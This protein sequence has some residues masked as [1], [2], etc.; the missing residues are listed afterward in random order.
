M[1]WHFLMMWPFVVNGIVFVINLFVSGNWKE[2]FPDNKTFQKLIPF[3]LFDLHLNKKCPVF[4]GKYNPAQRVIYPAVIL[5]GL[6]SII[7]GVAI[8]KPVQAG[9]LSQML[10]GY[11]SSRFLHFLH[12]Y[13]DWETDRKSTRLNSSHEFVSRMPS[14]A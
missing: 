9:F 10:G 11:E 5:M 6:G 7:S 12:G 2:L 14:S 13:R 1:G 3:I 4:E 8:Y